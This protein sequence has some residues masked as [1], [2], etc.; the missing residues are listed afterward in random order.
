MTLA[1]LAVD[2]SPSSSTDRHRAE[3]HAFMRQHPQVYEHFYRFCV[4]AK[5]A[6]V[7][8]LGAKLVWE[9]LRWELKV[10]G[11]S[12]PAKYAL[13]NNYVKTFAERVVEENPED[14]TNFF[15]FRGRQDD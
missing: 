9:R 1:L 2:D 14:F 13:N 11:R 12:E 8:K 4:D 15:S 10:V 6:G 5:V 3:A 7:Q